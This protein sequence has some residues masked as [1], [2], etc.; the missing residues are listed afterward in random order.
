MVEGGDA[1]EEDEAADEEGDDERMERREPCFERPYSMQ[2][3]VIQ[4]PPAARVLAIDR[5]L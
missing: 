2:M 4:L 1:A 3:I 5:E